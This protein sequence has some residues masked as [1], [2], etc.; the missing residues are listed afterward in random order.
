LV[1]ADRL[2]RER[3]TPRVVAGD[4]ERKIEAGA[5][6]ERI[7]RARRAR[8]R[9]AAERDVDLRSGLEVVERYRTTDE[10]CN[11]LRIG[12]TD[13]RA[14]KHSLEAVAPRQCREKLDARPLG[15]GLERHDQRG[16]PHMPPA[17]RTER[18]RHDHLAAEFVPS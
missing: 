7:E 8:L 10:F 2:A 6:F 11:P 13:S 1:D 4:G 12:R 14:P 15:R 3:E 5:E 16:R 18:D 17:I 9:T